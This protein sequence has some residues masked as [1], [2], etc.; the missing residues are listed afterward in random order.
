MVYDVVS[1]ASPPNFDVITA[2]AVAVGHIII[3]RNVSANRRYS[4]C[5]KK[6]NTMHVTI[7]KTHCIIISHR[8]NILGFSA[9]GGTLQN[10]TKSMQKRSAGCSISTPFTIPPF[11][12]AD[13]G[14]SLPMI[15]PNA[16]IVIDMGKAQFFIKRRSISLCPVLCVLH[17]PQCRISRVC[18]LPDAVQ[19]RRSCVVRQYIR[20]RTSGS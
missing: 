10:V 1:P 9:D 18:V 17:A 4:V 16:P 19:N 15:Y 11:I 20:R 3:S 13:K 12:S 7:K 14:S 5:G 2:Q 6:Y 8:C